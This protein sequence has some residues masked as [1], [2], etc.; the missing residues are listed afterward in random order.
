VIEEL[1]DRY[2]LSMKQV[3]SLKKRIA[4]KSTA[5]KS[6]SIL[7]GIISDLK[8][9]YEISEGIIS[10]L[11]ERLNKKE[12]P[13]KKKPVPNGYFEGVAE[14][15]K[16]S[17]AEAKAIFKNV[18]CRKQAFEYH[19]EERQKLANKPYREFPYMKESTISQSVYSTP[20]K[21]DNDSEK[22]ARIIANSF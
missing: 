3:K 7:E 15:H 18:G 2:T 5:N 8:K 19:L 10:E 20:E 22:L 17:V 6:D 13:K 12:A 21:A 14:K 16:I 1:K 11:A 9:R 4:S